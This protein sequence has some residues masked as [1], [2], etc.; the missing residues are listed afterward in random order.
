MFDTEVPSIF[1]DAWFIVRHTLFELVPVWPAVLDGVVFQH[2]QSFN[3]FMIGVMSEA[4]ECLATILLC[5]L[6]HV[7]HILQEILFV[8]FIGL[9][10]EEFII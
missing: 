9:C 1:G 2:V 3:V 7:E 6:L 8:S 5:K 10:L 4:M